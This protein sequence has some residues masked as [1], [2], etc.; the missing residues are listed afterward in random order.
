[1]IKELPG[2]LSIGK[3]PTVNKICRIRGQLKFI[4]LILKRI[5]MEGRLRLFS[6]TVCGMRSNLIILMSLPDRWRLDRTNAMRL[7]E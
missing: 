3:N 5:S 6:G 4:F 2:M 1:M 7:L